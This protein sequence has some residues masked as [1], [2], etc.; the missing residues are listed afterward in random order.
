MHVILNKKSS[1]GVNEFREYVSNNTFMLMS[2]HVMANVNL[3]YLN[4]GQICKTTNMTGPFGTR[5]Q[6]L[7]LY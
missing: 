6:L 4:S 1:N 5:I 2:R 3:F 7:N